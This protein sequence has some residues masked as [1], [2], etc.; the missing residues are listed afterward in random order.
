VARSK[1]LVIK[2]EQLREVEKEGRGDMC[3]QTNETANKKQNP[4]NHNANFV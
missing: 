3:I 4:N 1:R 2:E